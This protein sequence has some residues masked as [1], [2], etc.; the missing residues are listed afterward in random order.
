MP[1]ARRSTSATR[2]AGTSGLPRRCP[3]RRD[4]VRHPP[5]L[6][7]Q[8]LRAHR[9]RHRSELWRLRR[10]CDAPVKFSVLKVRNA[11]AGR[12]GSRPP[13]TWNGCWATCGR[14]P[15]CT[16]SPKSTRR[17]ARSSRATPTTPSSPTA[18]AFFDV[19]D[20]TRTVTGDRTEFLGRNGT[21]A[22][23]AAMRRV[24]A[25]RQGRRRPRSLRRAP[26]AVRARRR[27]GARDHLQARRAG[28]DARRR[29]A[30]WCSGSAAG[31]RAQRARRGLAILE[32]HARR[33]PGGNARP[34]R[35][36]C[37]P[38]A[39][40]SIRPW[41]A[42][43]GRARL[44]S[45]GRRVRL[46]RSA[47]GRD[48]AGACRAASA[49]RASAALRGPPVPRRRRPALVASARR[50]AAC[51]R[52]S[53]TTTS[54]CPWRRAATSRRT[55]DTGV[56][57]EPIHFLEGRPVNARGGIVLRSARPV[58]GVGHALRALRARDPATACVRRAR[59]AADRLA[60]T[61]TTA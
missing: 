55:G 33:G 18:I 11:P 19:D 9:G 56:L 50:A 27:A 13:A 49:A 22:N 30:T 58:R 28:R 34:V 15:R 36:T 25:L 44:L 39:G 29:R 35:R 5:R 57:D 42:A 17:A 46:P 21:L 16:S 59:P 38:T 48:G 40:S 14:N 45:V 52:I 24:A 1:A 43:C 4:A 47:A 7:L 37:W 54:G 32:P 10:D 12:A 6:R 60:A 23:P 26:G 53:R 41:P 51:A 20:A 8:R 31:G 3:P 61:G 2:R